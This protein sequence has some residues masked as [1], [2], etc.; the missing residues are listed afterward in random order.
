MSEMNLPS[1][2]EWRQ[3]QTEGGAMRRAKRDAFRRGTM[4]PLAPANV[5]SGGT[6]T[7]FEIENAKKVKTHEDNEKK[8]KKKKKKDD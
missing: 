7:P 1:F 3:M 6:G 2:E 5:N 4:P 8:S